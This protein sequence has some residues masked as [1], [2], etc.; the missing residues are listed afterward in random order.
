MFC[1]HT[2]RYLIVGL[3]NPGSR[4]HQT[5]HNMG[6]M[7]IDEIS[8]HFDIPLSTHHF[9]AMTGRGIAAEQDV[10]IAKPLSFMNLAGLPVANLIAYF[11]ISVSDMLVVHDDMDLTFGRLKIK[12][13]GGSGGHKG[14][15]SI[16]DTLND[17]GFIRI[18]LGIGRPETDVGVTDYVLQSFSSAEIQAAE[19]LASLARDAVSTI[20]CK[21]TRE[22]MNRFNR[23]TITI[24]SSTTDGGK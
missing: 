3:G 15:Q 13:K 19:K 6:F 12:E 17:D 9:N 20:L 14:V 4:Y 7:A 21:G 8:R 24:S 5:R 18:R 16:I 10:I 23:M 2:P 22:G 11:G 1:E